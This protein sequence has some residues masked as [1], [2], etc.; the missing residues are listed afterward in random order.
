M[1]DGTNKRGRHFSIERRERK[2]RQTQT[3]GRTKKKSLLTLFDP[4]V[5]RICRESNCYDPERVKNFLKE[6]KLTDQLPLIIVCDRSVWWR[7]KRRKKR[8]KRMRRKKRR[9]QRRRRRR[10][11]S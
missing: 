9:R 6:A 2:R 8:R 5:E 4:Q 11:R 1:Q 7:S 3:D 10:T